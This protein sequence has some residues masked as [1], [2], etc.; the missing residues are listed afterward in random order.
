MKGESGSFL[1][2]RPAL[3]IA[4]EAVHIVR[5]NPAALAAYFA[6]TLPFALAALYYWGDMSYGAGAED[7]L[8]VGAL[9]LTLLFVW[10]KAWHTVFA[11]MLMDTLTG[12]PDPWTLRRFGRMAVN[13]AILQ[14]TGLLVLPAAVGL[15]VPLGWA[16]GFYQSAAVLDDGRTGLTALAGRSWEQ[17]KHWPRQNHLLIWMLS[18]LALIIAALTG[19]VLVPVIQALAPL[20]T[21]ALLMLL[22]SLAALLIVAAAPLGVILLANLTALIVAVPFLLHALLG[23]ELGITRA[24][25]GAWGSSLWGA[26]VV[27]TVVL[28]D[29]VFKAAYVLRC[30][31][32]RSLHTGEDLRSALRRLGPPLRRGI[33]AGL[34]ILAGLAAGHAAA[35]GDGGAGSISPQALEDAI[36]NTLQQREYRWRFPREFSLESGEEAGFIVRMLSR[37]GTHLRDWT[38]ALREWLGG[39]VEW[40]G[41]LFPEAPAAA[42]PGGIFD[43]AETVEWVLWVLTAVLAS[44]AAVLLVRMWLKSRRQPIP[45][46]E[47]A[48]AVPVDLEDERLGPEALPEEDWLRLA[49]D[50]ASQAEWRLAVRAMHLAVLVRLSAARLVRLARHKTNRDY[51]RELDRRAHAEETALA[52]WRRGVPLFERVWYGPEQAGEAHFASMHRIYAGLADAY[53]ADGTTKE[54]PVAPTPSA[55]AG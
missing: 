26:A 32:G 53:P 27:L 51:T 33:L 13:Q 55:S 43:W 18:P 12:A 19:L 3:D 38:E 5:R 1:A 50:M 36:R 52:L 39:V 15:L 29:P 37:I 30:F 47:P 44:V 42:S 45:A 54:A 14:P 35:Q 17:A 22:L 31:E 48:P 4:E 41:D 11:R 34:T 10:M 49:Q 16:Y 20:W 25:P 8:A 9:G 23:I 46:A 21:Q 28:L 40:I 7:H 24:G 6:G 2:G